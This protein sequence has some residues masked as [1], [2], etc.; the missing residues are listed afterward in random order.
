[1]NTQKQ[2]IIES[3]QGKKIVMRD[4]TEYTATQTMVRL[5]KRKTKKGNR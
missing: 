1:M 5:T 4:G 3:S 2:R